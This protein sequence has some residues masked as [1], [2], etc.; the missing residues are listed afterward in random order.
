MSVLC[1]FDHLDGGQSEV[2]FNQQSWVLFQVGCLR[3]GKKS[4]LL[5]GEFD[6]GMLVCFKL[7][8]HTWYYGPV[9]TNK[10]EYI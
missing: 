8:F 2:K 5:E 10:F 7:C 6:L 3:G 9:S 1:G 4:K